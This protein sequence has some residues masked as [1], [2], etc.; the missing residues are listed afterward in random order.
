MARAQRIQ[1]AA[2]GEAQVLVRQ[3]TR[4]NSGARFF[5]PYSSEIAAGEPTSFKTFH[6]KYHGQ[7]CELVE[8]VSAGERRKFG[9]YNFCTDTIVEVRFKDGRTMEMTTDVLILLENG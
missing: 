9:S 4:L 7:T 3:A 1:K 2:A 5:F 6:A 8:V